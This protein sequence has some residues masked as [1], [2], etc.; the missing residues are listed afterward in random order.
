MKI[1]TLIIGAVLALGLFAAQT[2]A[3]EILEKTLLSGTN[4]VNNGANL[5]TNVNNTTVSNIYM[6]AGVIYTN[7]GAFSAVTL[8]LRP[9]GALPTYY[10]T[11]SLLGTNAA[12]TNNVSFVLRTV[13]IAGGR[14]STESTN[15]FTY[16]I[17]MNGNASVVFCVPI[18]ALTLGTAKQIQVSTITHTASAGAGNTVIEQLKILGGM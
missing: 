14:V 10:L 18:P 6:R 2:Q 7:T 3:V 4:V 12:T 17:N 8:Q 13:P 9:D 16:A 15:A 11:G 1:K 5:Y